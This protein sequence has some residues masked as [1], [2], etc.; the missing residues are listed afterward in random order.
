[1]TFTCV[2]P[3]PILR[4]AILLAS[5]AVMTITHARGANNFLIPVALSEKQRTRQDI[6]WLLEGAAHRHEPMLAE[7]LAR[8]MIGVLQ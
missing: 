5:P 7:R 4:E 2:P 3:M 1:H 6:Q 8:E